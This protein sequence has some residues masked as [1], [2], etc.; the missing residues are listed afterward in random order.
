MFS[1]HIEGEK[2]LVMPS[3]AGVLSCIACARDG[4]TVIVDPSQTYLKW[5]KRNLEANGF[6]QKH[7]H[8]TCAK[9]IDWLKGNSG[10]RFHTAFVELPPTQED[11]NELIAALR[12]VMRP[13]GTAFLISRFKRVSAGT[14]A[15]EVTSST[16]AHDFERT[17]Q[18]FRAWL[19][20]C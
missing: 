9:P 10:R 7:N 3:Q 20:E 14:D 11:A 1:E 13:G 2:V 12:K 17:P 5:A 4:R 16:L 8:F 18:A 6:G 15:V 19:L